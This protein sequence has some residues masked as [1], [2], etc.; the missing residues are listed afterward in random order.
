[1]ITYRS[2]QPQPLYLVGT[3]TQS[4]VI[5]FSTESQ[6]HSSERSYTGKPQERSSRD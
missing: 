5:I 1:M 4:P 6:T 2:M 3:A